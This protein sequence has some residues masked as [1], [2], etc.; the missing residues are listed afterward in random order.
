MACT[1]IVGHC[2]FPLVACLGASS[3]LGA[4]DFQS[5]KVWTQEES[6]VKWAAVYPGLWPYARDHQGAAGTQFRSEALF[7]F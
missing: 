2:L 3:S 7:K 4:G 1:A 5:V 6:C